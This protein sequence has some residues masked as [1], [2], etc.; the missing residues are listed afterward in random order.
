MS[1]VDHFP[2]VVLTLEFLALS[3]DILLRLFDPSLK[4]DAATLASVTSS[5]PSEARLTVFMCA[6]SVMGFF[7]D[8]KPLLQAWDHVSIWS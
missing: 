7:C 2:T 6:P 8:L 3:T 5:V 1:W 4:D